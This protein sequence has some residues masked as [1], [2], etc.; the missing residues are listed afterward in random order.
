MALRLVVSISDTDLEH[1][2]QVLEKAGKQAD[3]GGEVQLIRRTRALLDAARRKGLSG[4]VK[5]RLHDLGALIRML[6]DRE[7][8][9]EAEGRRRIRAVMS[10]FADALD[11]IPDE[12]P[13]L[14]YV[15][16]ALMTELILRELRDE[17]DAYR[18]FCAYRDEQ[19]RLRG[20]KAHVDR[21]DWLAAKRRQL[22]LRMERRR[23][24]RHRHG[25]RAAPTPPLLAFRT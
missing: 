21:D 4:A 9:L 12:T 13:G 7:W 15:D 22:F 1:Y 19:T 5:K 16:D 8:G 25:S 3:E 18:D 17:L 11:V 2:R 23:E 20:P 24:E 10:Y 14:G 6:E